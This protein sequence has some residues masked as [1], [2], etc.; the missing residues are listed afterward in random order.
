MI[1]RAFGVRYVGV[2][3]DSEDILGSAPVLE[4]HPTVKQRVRAS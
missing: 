4:L 2:L 3:P 1:D